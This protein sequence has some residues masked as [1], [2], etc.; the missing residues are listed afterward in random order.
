MKTQL[1]HLLLLI[2]LCS[3]ACR[4]NNKVVP[5]PKSDSET[6]EMKIDAI[7]FVLAQNYFVKNTV[8]SIT[9]PKIETV[10]A[11]NTYFGAATTMGENGK[12]TAV[13]FEKEYAI[14]LVLPLTDI[15][16][17]IQPVSL[18]KRNNNSVVLEYKVTSGNK[19]S[20]TSRPFLLLFVDKKYD[21]NISLTR[22]N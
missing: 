2:V 8:D 21:G 4:N 9:N 22:L 20:F 6:T 10:E 16:T 11:F 19:Q 5:Q 7:P 17:T 13:N 18:S 12:P 14:A 3:A 1:I 15:N